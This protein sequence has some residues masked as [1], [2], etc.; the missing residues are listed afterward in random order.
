MPGK[1]LTLVGTSHKYTA[2]EVL[3]Q[4]GHSKLGD[5][6]SLLCPDTAD[7]RRWRRG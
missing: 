5:R 7:D 6:W 1:S 2:T 3:D 4:K